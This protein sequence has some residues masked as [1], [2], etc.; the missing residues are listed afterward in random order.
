MPAAGYNDSLVHTT[1]GWWSG[2]RYRSR[3]WSWSRSRSYAWPGAYR[4]NE[5][6]A[7]LG[8][9]ICIAIVHRDKQSAGSSV[10]IGSRRPV[11]VILNVNK[12]MTGWKRWSV[13]AV[14]NYTSNLFSVWQAPVT[15]T[16]VIGFIEA[17]YIIQPHLPILIAICA[18][19][20]R[21]CIGA[22]APD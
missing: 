10:I 2:C 6:V 14:I 18:V 9:D 17:G 3:S 16:K 13:S 12:G 21:W 4:P 15:V 7:C 5:I 22:L 19:T 11:T 8:K 20:H 1:C